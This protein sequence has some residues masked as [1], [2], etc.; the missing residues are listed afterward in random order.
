MDT[1][2]WTFLTLFTLLLLSKTF[3][4]IELF[5]EKN[6][7]YDL[8]DFF[9]LINNVHAYFGKRG[10]IPYGTIRLTPTVL[11]LVVT[12]PTTFESIAYDVEYTIPNMDITRV[13]RSDMTFALESV[14]DMH[15]L[16]K[17]SPIL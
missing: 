14:N 3:R 6:Y 16:I 10:Q 11:T 1:I 7:A 12:D 5:T 8:R 9:R 2:F 13:S 17:K 4:R 15:T